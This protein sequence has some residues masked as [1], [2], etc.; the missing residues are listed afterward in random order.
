MKMINRDREIA[1][2]T[3]RLKAM[4]RNHEVAILALSQ[5]NRDIEKRSGGMPQLSDLQE[6]GGLEADADAVLMIWEPGKTDEKR[7]RERM[8][9]IAKNRNGFTGTVPLRLHG[10]FMTLE[11]S[12]E[13]L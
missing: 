4:A 10:E 2:M 12:D 7:N 9:R 8:L 5:L 3:K 13:E 1:L 6:S 11:E